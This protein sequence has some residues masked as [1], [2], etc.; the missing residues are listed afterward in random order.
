[1]LKC[2]FLKKKLKSTILRI[3][4][5]QL[6]LNIRVKFCQVLKKYLLLETCE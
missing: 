2:M 3:I 1:M 4:T 6:T 5:F